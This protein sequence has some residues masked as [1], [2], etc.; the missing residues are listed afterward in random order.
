MLKRICSLI[1]LSLAL[2]ALG[3]LVA[4]EAL[5][6]PTSVTLT[7]NSPLDE[8][9]PPATGLCLSTPSGKCT[10]RAAIMLANR[11]ASPGVTIVVPSGIYTLTITVIPPTSGPASQ[12]KWVLGDEE[13]SNPMLS[14]GYTGTGSS[15]T[16]YPLG[17][18]P[19]PPP[20]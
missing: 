18:K 7:V 20:A 1:A 11:V 19:P 6:A 10:L 4:R 13:L 5:A 2:V 8:P 12:I 15:S 3:N 9:L 17:Q 14:N 16:T